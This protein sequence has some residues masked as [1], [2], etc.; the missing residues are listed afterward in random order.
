MKIIIGT[1]DYPPID[2]TIL[3]LILHPPIDKLQQK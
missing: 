1:A 2:I 3:Q